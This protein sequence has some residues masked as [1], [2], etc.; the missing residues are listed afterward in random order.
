M[1]KINIEN[2]NYIVT[3]DAQK[4][5][6]MDISGKKNVSFFTETYNSYYEFEVLHN[7]EEHQRDTN[8]NSHGFY[9]NSGNE[10][11]IKALFDAKDVALKSAVAERITSK[12]RSD[13]SSDYDVMYRKRNDID[14]YGINM[15]FPHL[16]KD[17][18]GFVQRGTY[19]YG[20][21][22]TTNAGP[23]MKST[24]LLDQKHNVSANL[25]EQYTSRPQWN[26]YLNPFDGIA[27]NTDTSTL[28]NFIVTYQY[29]PLKNLISIAEGI[30]SANSEKFL[31]SEEDTVE[32]AA[33]RY[34]SS[35]FEFK[36]LLATES[37]PNAGLSNLFKPVY[38]FQNIDHN[39]LAEVP[40]DNLAT[41]E[42][43]NQYYLGNVYAD[44]IMA[45][46]AY[47]DIYDVNTKKISEFNRIREYT[48]IQQTGTQIFVTYF[49]DAKYAASGV[50]ETMNYISAELSTIG[51]PLNVVESKNGYVNDK[52]RDYMKV[53]HIAAINRFVSMTNHKA[54]VYSV[55]IANLDKVLDTA[56]NIDKEN[57]VAKQNIKTSIRNSIR[58]IVD[59]FAPAH[60]QY[61]DV[62][63]ANNR[64][65]QIKSMLISDTR[66]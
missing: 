44:M 14:G 36:K 16:K 23:V 52:N 34:A 42:K 48:G 53:E 7:I 1:P 66:C 6:N 2:I 21:T 5:L 62:M 30:I 60:T 3:G 25:E 55:K 10:K 56:E 61:F 40:I 58:R 31:S 59:N 57:Y 4:I 35:Y 26:F 17:P 63:N 54:N 39:Y 46:N 11:T 33:K 41:P 27:S 45:K 9:K 29:T 49:D 64:D 28:E 18:I 24:D 51:G 65:K 37:D 15:Y 38:N 47:D 12:K 20:I 32:N 19:S 50:D 43:R 22:D 13:I 8:P